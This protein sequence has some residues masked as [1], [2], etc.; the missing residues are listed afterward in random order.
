MDIQGL[1]SIVGNLTYVAL[2]MIA[3]WGVFCVVMVWTR[4]AQ[5]R[6]RNEDAQLEFLDMLDGFATVQILPERFPV[7]SKL[8]GGLKGF[9]FNNC[10]VGPFNL[11]P[12]KVV[13]KWGWHLMGFAQK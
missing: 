12:K 2:V 9:L 6:F 7:K 10:F 3:L 8:H 5:K 1:T 11:I 13:R 4:V